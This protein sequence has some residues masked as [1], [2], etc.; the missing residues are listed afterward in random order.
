[1]KQESRR[2]RFSWKLLAIAKPLGPQH[3]PRRKRSLPAEKGTEAAA[4]AKLRQQ[5]GAQ[6]RDPYGPNRGGGVR[7]DRGRR[8]VCGG[9]GLGDGAVFIALMAISCKPGRVWCLN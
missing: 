4:A 1:M 7:G 6:E 8:E 5:K 3:L 2:D 9:H